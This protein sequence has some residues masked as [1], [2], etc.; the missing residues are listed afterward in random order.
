MT[1]DLERQVTEGR[2]VTERPSVVWKH[3]LPL[4]DRVELALPLGARILHFGHQHGELTLWEVHDV[5]NDDIKVWHTFRIVGTGRLFDMA[6]LHFIGT[7]QIGTF[8]WH[9]FEVVQNG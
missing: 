9:L 2:I 1:T 4:A 7:T 6:P 5:E 8:V 3:I